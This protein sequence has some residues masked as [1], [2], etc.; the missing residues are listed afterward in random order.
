MKLA[1]A[2][3]KIVRDVRARQMEALA[4]EMGASSRSLSLIQSRCAGPSQVAWCGQSVKRKNETT[5]SRIAGIPSMTKSQRQP[6]WP[7]QVW[8]RI[9]PATGEPITNDRSEERR[10]GKE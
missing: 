4:V 6:A 8:P 7:N 10:V 2:S 9:Q 3:S 5:P 1:V